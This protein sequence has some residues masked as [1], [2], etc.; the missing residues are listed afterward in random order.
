[1]M[2]LEKFE[3]EIKEYNFEG[4][5]DF[6]KNCLEYLDC[7]TGVLDDLYSELILNKYDSLDELLYL[8]D[9]KEDIARAVYFGNIKSWND[10]HFF[11]NAYGNIESE[12]DYEYYKRFVD[13]KETILKEMIEFIDEDNFKKINNIDE[14]IKYIEK[15]MF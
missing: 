1:M 12:N 5:E 3:E 7:H 11:F 10:E 6:L 15:E 2:T 14:L 13:Y 4:K 8:I 9:S